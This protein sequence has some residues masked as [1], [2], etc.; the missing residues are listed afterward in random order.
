MNITTRHLPKY[1][2]PFVVNQSTKSYTSREQATWRYIMH[3]SVDFFK[4][5]AHPVYLDGLKKTGITLDR[6]PLIEEMDEKLREIGW[7][8]VPV[9]GFIPPAAFLDFQ[10]RSILPIATDMRTAEHLHYTPAPD[11][12]HEAAGHA[13]ILADAGYSEYLKRYANVA[14]KAI[15]SEDDVNLYKAIR[16]LSDVKENPDCDAS[17]IRNAETA[18]ATAVSNMKIPS[19]A[20]LTARM[21]WWT[22]EYGLIG[23]IEKPLIYGAGLLSSVGESQNCLSEQVKKIPLSIECVQTSYDITEPQPQLFVAKDLQHLIDVLEEFENTLA[24]K[25]GGRFGLQKASEAKTTSTI[26]LDSQLQISGIIDTHLGD[27]DFFRLSSPTQIAH[28]NKELPGHSKDYHQHGFSSPLGRIKGLENQP[29]NALKR[30]NFA[31][32]GVV[33]YQPSELSFVNGFLVKGIP[34]EFL[35]IGGVVKIIKWKNCHVSRQGEVF[36]QPEW[37]DFDMVIGYEVTSV[38]GGPADQEAFGNIDL[39]AAETSPARQT[40]FSSEELSLFRAYDRVAN[41]RHTSEPLSAAEVEQFRIAFSNE[42]LLHLE[43]LEYFAKIGDANQQSKTERFLKS[44]AVSQ[45]SH[46]KQLIQQGIDWTKK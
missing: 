20:N 37:G 26:Q 9:S 6:I 38:F 46:V 35:E 11:I 4:D 31:N 24:Y 16:T 19:E 44:L 34:S 45:P 17:D 33:Q 39:N 30:D 13:P 25:I 10:S 8:A 42:W 14:R 18:L 3:Q 43:I 40:P 41:C 23:E 21:N 1:L 7:G 22:V 36:F 27:V 29:V 28:N 2:K 32:I 12:V 15:Y 5:H